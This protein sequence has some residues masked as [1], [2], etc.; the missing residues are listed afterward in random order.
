MYNSIE[1]AKAAINI[2][3]KCSLCQNKKKS[4]FANGNDNLE[5]MF[6][7]DYPREEEEMSQDL[8]SGRAGK[9]MQQAMIGH[10]INK[11]K[12]YFT[13]LVKCN[14]GGKEPQKLEINACLDYL[15]SQVVIIKPQ[16]VFLMG[17]VVIKEIL[18]EENTLLNLRGQVVDK[19]GIK[20]I[21]TCNVL[22]LFVD[23]S[24]KIDFW[25]DLELLKLEADKLNIDLK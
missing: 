10:G 15:R 20:Y 22:S 21:P 8:W 4:F 9:L 11:D 3:N 16:I 1:E 2:C 19:K 5:V 18:G 25:N 13:S 6:I 14:T 24:K 12:I 23:E 17:N 7:T